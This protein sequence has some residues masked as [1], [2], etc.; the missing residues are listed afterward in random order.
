MDNIPQKHSGG[1]M[2]NQLDYRNKGARCNLHCQYYRDNR[3]W[4]AAYNRANY[5]TAEMCSDYKPINVEK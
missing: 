3:C 5:K 4:I 1:I 2:F